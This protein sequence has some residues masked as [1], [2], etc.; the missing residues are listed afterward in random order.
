MFLNV[1]FRSSEV[2]IMFWTD[3]GGSGVAQEWIFQEAI[4]PPKQ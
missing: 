4:P 3:C 2:G 1:F